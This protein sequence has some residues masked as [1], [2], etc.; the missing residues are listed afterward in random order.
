MPHTSEKPSFGFIGIG[1]YLIIIMM[2]NDLHCIYF[3]DC[4][5]TLTFYIYSF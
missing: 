4:S 5:N 1:Q 3:V 2:N